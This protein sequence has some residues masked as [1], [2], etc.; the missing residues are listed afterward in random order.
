MWSCVIVTLHVFHALVSTNQREFLPTAF[1][2][3]GSLSN[4]V[5]R[6]VDLVVTVF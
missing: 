5:C 2:F 6:G 4:Y 1:H 3:S